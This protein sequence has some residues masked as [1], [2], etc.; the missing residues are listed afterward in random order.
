[1]SSL[2]DL[3]FDSRTDDVLLDVAAGPFGSCAAVAQA[4]STATAA[5]ATRMRTRDGQAEALAIAKRWFED[6]ISKKKRFMHFLE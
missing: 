6:E 1:M 3:R 5:N 4:G 2:S